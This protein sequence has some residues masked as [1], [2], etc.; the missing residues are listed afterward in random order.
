MILAYYT[1]LQLGLLI[2]LSSPTNQ[3]WW[4]GESSVL[5]YQLNARP[6]PNCKYK[7]SVNWITCPLEPMC[8][9]KNKGISDSTMLNGETKR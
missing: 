5:N 9:F 7:I 1:Y 3:S 4:W 8:M 6:K 2:K